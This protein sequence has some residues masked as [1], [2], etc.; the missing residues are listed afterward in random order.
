MTFESHSRQLSTGMASERDSEINS[1]FSSSRTQMQHTEARLRVVN[2]TSAA[3]AARTSGTAWLQSRWPGSGPSHVG[4]TDS[5]P[6]ARRH[7]DGDP[8]PP[9]HC[10]PGSRES[11]QWQHWQAP[12]AGPGVTV[13]AAADARPRRRTDRPSEE[14]QEAAAGPGTRVRLGVIHRD[15]QP[16]QNG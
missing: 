16:G 4:Y 2:R 8:S 5:E 3:A 1:A 12:P 15:W 10:G 14:V 6:A 13:A 7:R 11:L 9:T